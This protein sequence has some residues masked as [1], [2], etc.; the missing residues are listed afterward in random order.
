VHVA[1][2]LGQHRRLVAGARAHVEHPL[3]VPQPERLADA[4]DHVRLGDR[5]AHADRQCAVVV[6]T[7]THALGNEELARDALHR[8]EHP[9]VR[10]VA[11][12]ELPLDHPGSF[13]GPISRHG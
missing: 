10:D 5:L 11:S 7:C 4:R 1:A 2:E 12:P 13:C 6:G 9:L 8:L 3:A